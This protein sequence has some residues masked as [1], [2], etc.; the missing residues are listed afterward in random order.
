MTIYNPWA[1]SW[2][3]PW[4]SR[5]QATVA[6]PQP[7]FPPPWPLPPRPQWVAW[8]LQYTIHR[9]IHRVIITCLCRFS[10]ICW[11]SGRFWWL[12]QGRCRP[13]HQPNATKTIWTSDSDTM[14]LNTVGIN[15]RPLGILQCVASTHVLSFVVHVLILPPASWKPVLVHLPSGADF[16][17]LNIQ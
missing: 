9:T 1:S 11:F 14:Y 8:R 4:P 17:W 12:K 13:D 7:P 16:P 10:V 15:N 5:R 3:A 2:P 6:Q